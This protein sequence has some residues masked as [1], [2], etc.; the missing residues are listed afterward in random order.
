MLPHTISHVSKYHLSILP[1]VC[2]QQNLK[3]RFWPW[4][5][6]F[7][8]LSFPDYWL[9]QLITAVS[10][11]FLAILGKECPKYCSLNQKTS[12]YSAIPAKSHTLGSCDGASICILGH[13]FSMQGSFFNFLRFPGTIALLEQ[14]R[15]RQGWGLTAAFPATQQC[16]LKMIPPCSNGFLRVLIQVMKWKPQVLEGLCEGWAEAGSVNSHSHCAHPSHGGCTYSCC[17]LIYI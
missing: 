14:T 15:H 11:L 10:N 3:A 1:E 5:Q 13:L 9:L 12:E 7:W 8:S 17:N 4:K 2:F 6:F 16:C